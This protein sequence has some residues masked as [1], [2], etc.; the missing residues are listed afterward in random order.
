MSA[1]V[2]IT[3]APG[4][5]KQLDASFIPVRLPQPSRNNRLMFQPN[6]TTHYP[7]FVIEVAFTNETRN[8]LLDDASDKYFSVHTSIQCWLGVKIWKGQR[9]FWSGWGVSA[10]GGQGLRI[11]E[12]TEDAQGMACTFPVVLPANTPALPGQFAIP[13]VHI[14]HPNVPPAAVPQALVFPFE[15]LRQEIENGFDRM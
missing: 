12:Q 3:Y 15:S 4:S 13:S 11:I 9:V 1:N 5:S 6:S 2:G 8:K 10:A 14:Y 7:S